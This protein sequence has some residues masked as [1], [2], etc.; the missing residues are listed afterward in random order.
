MENSRK[1][2]ITIYDLAVKLNI[3]PTTVSRGLQDHPAINKATKKKI[4]ELAEEMGYRSNN[5][6]RNLRQ[7]KSH[8]L[9]VIVPRLNS[10]FTST[11]IAGME[12][13]ANKAG[14]NLIISQSM[15]SY[16]KEVANA[17]TMFNNRV[18]GLLVSLVYDSNNIEHFEPFFEKNLPLIFFDRVAEH[19]NCTNIVIDNRKAGFEATMHLIEQ[20]CKRIA[21]ISA[22]SLRNVYAERLKG[23]KEALAENSIEFQE[24]NIIL[25]NLSQEAGADAAEIILKM[26][27]KVDGVF[28]A[29]DNAAIGCMLALKKAGVSIPND[30]AFAGFNNDPI[31]QVIEPNLTTV[32]YHGFEMGETAAHNLIN[33]LKGLSNIKTTN[34]IV[35]RSE[36][37]K[38][39]SSLRQEL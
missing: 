34:R 23:Y 25:G 36:L 26:T 38:R 24:D 10:H 31:S 33:H 14:Y 32:H 22:P 13:V 3:S 28:A 15:E 27:P 29:N 30:I 17:K 11:V 9:G 4:Y 6:A 18:D 37:I 2:D 7:Q 35:L 12:N 5:F 8:T 1:K 20:G 39:A 19:K 16:K 21:H